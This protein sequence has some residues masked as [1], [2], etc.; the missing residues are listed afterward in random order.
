MKLQ[1]KTQ[2]RPL[3]SWS[4][5]SLIIM[6]ANLALLATVL[7][8]KPRPVTVS[9]LAQRAAKPNVLLI[10]VDDLNHWVRHLGRNKQ[11]ITPN[12]DRLAARGVTFANAYCAAP[13]CNPSRA[14]LMSG[15]R[16]STTGVYNNGIDWRPIVAPEKTLVTHF[17]GNG[18]Y[19]AGAGKIYH[20]GFDRKEEWDDYGRE[21][22][23]P[24]KLLNQTDGVGAIRFS[25]VD[26][27]DEGISDSGISVSKLLLNPWMFL[28]AT[29]E[30][31]RGE[32]AVFTS[33]ERDDL[34][35]LARLRGYRDV[36]ESSNIDLGTSF[37]SVPDEPPYEASNAYGVRTV[38]TLFVLDDGDVVDVVESWDRDGWNR[39]A[40]RLADLT[41]QAAEEVSSEGDG[42]PPFR[43]G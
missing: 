5:L 27:G 30:V 26:C 8:M 32:S 11:V 37:A 15:L 43:P 24:C 17:R 22:G 38:P 19:T 33:H 9:A 29:G 36:S 10:A 6:V 16:P 4:R 35:Y 21:R 7:L 41:G 12:I 25:P 31:Y 23:G 28:E 20:G 3:K 18:Y 34:T 39:A 1:S 2:T 42:L 13:I 40:A 14:A